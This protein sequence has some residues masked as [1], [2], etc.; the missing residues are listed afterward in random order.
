MPDLT[1]TNKSGTVTELVVDKEKKTKPVTFKDVQVVNEGSTIVLPDGMTPR[2]GIEWLE[3]REKESNAI[4]NVSETLDGFPLDCANALMLAVQERYGFKDLRATP[5]FFGDTPPSFFPIPTDNKGGTV[6][7]FVGRFGVPALNKNSFLQSYVAGFDKLGVVGE[8]KKKEMPEVKALLALARKHLKFNSLYRS[9]AVRLKWV[10]K[11]SW[12]GMTQGFDIPEFMPDIPADTKLFVNEETQYLIDA[13]IYTPITKTALCRKYHIP[14][15][16]AVLAEGPFGTGKTL[17]AGTTAALCQDNGW[18]F[19]YCDDVR[20]LKEAY[21]LAAAHF[22]PCVVFAEDL[23]V[24]MDSNKNHDLQNVLDG[25]DTKGAEVLLILTTNYPE[26]LDTSILRHGRIGEVIQ[27]QFPDTKTAEA[28]VRHYAGS[29]LA[30][31]ADL[32]ETAKRLTG[33]SPASIRATVERA[34][35]HSLSMSDSVELTGASLERSAVGMKHHL[36]LMEDNKPKPRTTIME[37]FGREIGNEAGRWL[38]HA[39]SELLT[40]K[41]KDRLTNSK[42]D[43]LIEANEAVLSTTK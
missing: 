41:E 26:R 34:K 7:V 8:V 12:S 29:L 21:R 13:S 1:H 4:V 31:D 43:E 18:T 40:V 28:L 10:E 15:K 39:V 33:L 22:G 24:V 27:F 14:L 25:I 20:K 9:K 35:Q 36:K 17:L 38:M 5:G 30:K 3:K 6:G 16:N 11:T 19:F 32:T 42:F 37:L 2:Q 23:D